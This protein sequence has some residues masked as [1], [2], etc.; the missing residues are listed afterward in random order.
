M[1]DSLWKH[2]SM[3]GEIGAYLLYKQHEGVV[4]VHRTDG[5]R[6][7]SDQNLRLPDRGQ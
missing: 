6:A 7:A 3:T 5:Q 4:G 2:F 1:R